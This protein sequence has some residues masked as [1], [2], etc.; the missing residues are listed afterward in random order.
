MNNKYAGCFTAIALYG[1]IILGIVLCIV[2][3]MKE[4]KLLAALS[5]IGAPLLGALVY[6]AAPESVHKDVAEYTRQKEHHLMNGGYRCPSCGRMSGHP[7][8]EIGKSIS[9]GTLGLASNKIGKSYKCKN[10]GYMW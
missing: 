2:F 3:T 6:N 4:Q 1:C 5:M 9:I 10:C 7:I 8:G